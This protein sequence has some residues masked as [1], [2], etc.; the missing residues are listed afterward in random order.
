MGARL[1]IATA[2]LLG[3]LLFVSGQARAAD[4]LTRQQNW[5]ALYASVVGTS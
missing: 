5:A 2:A 1:H 4:G 3:S